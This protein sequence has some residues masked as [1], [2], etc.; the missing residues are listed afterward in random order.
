MVIRVEREKKIFNDI[1]LIRLLSCLAVL[2]YHFNL[3]PGGYL[4]VC[5]FFVLSGYLA[6]ISAFR[7]E[8]FSLISYY[9]NRFLKIYFPLLIVVFI[10]ICIISFLPSINW[11]N[12][13]PETTSVILGYNNFWQ[14]S[15]NLDYFAR[16]VNSP[17]MH[18]WYIGILLQFELVFPFIFLFLRKIG[19][20]LTKVV[21]C[22]ILFLLSVIFAIYFYKNSLNSN[23]MVTYYNTFSRVFSLLFGMFLGFFHS[24]YGLIMPKVFEKK[25]INR[26]IFYGYL[27]IL[28]GLFIFIDASSKYFAISMILVS[29]ISCRLIDYGTIFVKKNLSIGERIIKAFSDMSYEIYL[30]QYPVIFLF[31]YVD[32]KNYFRFPIMVSVIL[33]LSYLLYF[34]K[35]DKKIARKR[36]KVLKYI[37]LAIFLSFSFYGVYQYCLAE[38]HTEEMKQLEEQLADNAKIIQIKQEEYASRLKQEEANWNATL[39]SLENGENELKNVVSNLAVVGVGDSVMLGAVGNL[40]EKFPNGYFDAKVSRTA[41][42]ANGI[43]SDLKNRNILSD[44]IVLN[45]GA[46]GDCDEACKTKIMETCGESNVFWVNTTNDSDVHVNDKLL[47]LASKYDNLH[48]IDWNLVSSGHFEYFLADGIHLTEVGRDVYTNTIYD[49]IY[50]VYLD[51][52]NT[53]KEVIMKQYEENQK[54]KISFY[55][56]DLLLNSFDYVQSEFPNAKFIINEDFNYEMLVDEIEKAVK[57]N[58]LTY[59]VVFAFDSSVSFSLEEYQRLIEL[60][61][62]CK[63]YILFSDENSAN[64]L[65][66]FGNDFVTT[67]NFYQEIKLNNDYLMVDEIHL[68]ERGN[69][70]L[71]VMISEVV[72]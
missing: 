10:T 25:I 69:Q 36:I 19:D 14:L 20:K 11:L 29:L 40:Y 68:T 70:A 21:P 58:T 33:L 13:K 43:L 55:G 65:T 1:N 9:S 27:L 62:D 60:C 51:E 5:I 53:K 42:V 30:F 8:K 16:H 7:K 3:L 17:F 66:G 50:Q 46:N 41:W 31:Q 59:N 38:D 2:L 22:I 34:C 49:A 15:A 23:V 63:V 54:T 61:K 56:N 71:G 32:I 26:I 18:F 37:V 4:A 35:F 67:I 12:L 48:I 47:A 6:C 44:N 72:K 45:L 28:I 57:D 39:M 64:V 52:Y 24:Y